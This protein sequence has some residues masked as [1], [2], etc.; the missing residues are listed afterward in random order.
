MQCLDFGTFHL[1][2]SWQSN[3]IVFIPCF[4]SSW[5]WCSCSVTDQDRNLFL[6]KTWIASQ[7]FSATFQ[8][9]FARGGRW[10]A[11]LKRDKVFTLVV[12]LFKSG[13]VKHT[14]RQQSYWMLLRFR[15]RR[16]KQHFN[17]I[18]NVLW[19]Y[20]F[21][22]LARRTFKFWS[23][24]PILPKYAL[25]NIE[26]KYLRFILCWHPMEE[27]IC[28]Q[29]EVTLTHNFQCLQFCLCWI[30]HPSPSSL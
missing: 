25:K 17:D 8:W 23:P 24:Q 4:Q 21:E 1:R 29:I 12:L 20:Q 15:N 30:V 13:R 10:L 16:L 3:F 5:A 14:F 2:F 7:I 27:F 11:R 28:P 9:C 22:S 6:A 18:A 19:I 26:K